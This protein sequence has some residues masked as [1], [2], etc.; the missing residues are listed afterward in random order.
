MIRYGALGNRHF[1]I[2]ISD[3]ASAITAFGRYSLMMLAQTGNEVFQKVLGSKE[4]NIVIS[5]Y[6]TDA[7]VDG[8]TIIELST[9]KTDIRTIYNLYNND[10]YVKLGIQDD[11]SVLKVGN[12]R[13]K[14]YNEV[15]NKVE[16]KHILYVSR[17]KSKQIRYKIKV[18]TNEEIIL[19]E[20]HNVY[21]YNNNSHHMQWIESKDIKIGDMLFIENVGLVNV[22]KKDIIKHNDYVYD[23]QVKDNE[24]FYANNILVHNCYFVL[25][26]IVKKKYG[27][28]IPADVEV[29]K[30]IDTF[31]K[32]IF[33]PAIAKNIER[34]LKNV[35]GYH[36][37]KRG[38]WF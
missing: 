11:Y 26:D 16:F 28:N 3:I 18:A 22:S 4:K 29:A 33:G 13:C 35:N 32:K 24:N 21:V 30:F 2:G 27:N 12:I 37:Y 7:C 19:T 10:E 23:I 17:R 38:N 20:K 9:H 25:D 5:N 31:E 34:N 6:A 1:G 36:N 14:S 15:T 8:N